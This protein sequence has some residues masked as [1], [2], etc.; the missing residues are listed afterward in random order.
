M[1]IVALNMTSAFN[2]V[3]KAI[4][5]S[6]FNLIK[7]VLTHPTP[8]SPHLP[9]LLVCGCDFNKIKIPNKTKEIG[10]ILK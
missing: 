2:S 7:G 6:V 10:S 1:G 5:K 3:S 4:P 9:Q 8:V